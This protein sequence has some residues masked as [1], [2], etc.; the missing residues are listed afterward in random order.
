[1]L[2]IYLQRSWIV[3]NTA[4]IA[5]TF[6]FIFGVSVLRMLGQTATIATAAGSFAVWM[7]PQLFAYATMI[8]ISKFLQAQS[9]IKPMALIALVAVVSHAF[10]SWLFMTKLGWGPIGAAA[11]L[12]GSW[13]FITLAQL[14]YV[15]WGSC[16]RAWSG[17]S[18]KA[19][20]NLKG[21]VHISFT[22]AVK[23]WYDF[24]YNLE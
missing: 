17:F 4:A 1:M 19:F 10:L 5:L 20:S 15:L 6:T 7:I 12:D 13:W 11:V 16:G 23:F 18:W 22:T 14:T 8:P 9:N 3:L 2:G 24:V 21:F